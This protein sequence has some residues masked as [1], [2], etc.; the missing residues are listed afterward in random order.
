MSL[1]FTA[2]NLLTG[3]ALQMSDLLWLSELSRKDPYKLYPPASATSGFAFG[4]VQ[5]DIPNFAP[6]DN[7]LVR[8]D[9]IFED[10]L[11]NAKDAN[12]L[13]IIDDATVATTTGDGKLLGTEPEASPQNPVAFQ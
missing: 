2:Q 13:R 1:P 11:L 9:K 5:W 3:F 8:A 7:S 6:F 12:G 10:I 4:A